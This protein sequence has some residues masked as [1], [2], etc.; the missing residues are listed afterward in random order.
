MVIA[1]RDQVLYAAPGVHD[2]CS[3]C[4]GSG[5]DV[6]TLVSTTWPLSRWVHFKSAMNRGRHR[7]SYCLMIA[8]IYYMLGFS[9]LNMSA[10]VTVQ[11]KNSPVCMYFYAKCVPY[12]YFS[13]ARI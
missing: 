4:Q 6:L 8:F 7:V 1:I 9:A 5:N 13:V 11:F 2:V 12:L 10:H 3:F